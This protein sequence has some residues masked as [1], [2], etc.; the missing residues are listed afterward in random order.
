MNFPCFRAVRCHEY[1]NM[2]GYS[3]KMFACNTCVLYRLQKRKTYEVLLRQI[4]LYR[5]RLLRLYCM[6]GCSHT[7]YACIS[8]PITAAIAAM[9][10]QM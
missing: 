1:V 10:A 6:C 5:D 9:T 7:W 8:T 3:V 2:V 4:R